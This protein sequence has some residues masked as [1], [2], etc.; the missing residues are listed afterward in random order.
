MSDS[1]IS[2]PPPSNFIHRLSRLIYINI[3]A[4]LELWLQTGYGLVNEFTDHLHTRLG[5]TRNYSASIN[6]H[7]SQITTVPSKFLQPAMSSSAIPWQRLLTMEILQLH[8]LSFCL[9][10]LP[11]RNQLTGRPSSLLYNFSAWTALPVSNSKSIV[12]CVF[13]S[14]ETCLPSSCSEAVILYSSVAN[15][16]LYRYSIKMFLGLVNL[17]KGQAYS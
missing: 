12:V 11:C 17:T 10:R 4:Y 14:A 5:I 6:F 1:I 8:A 3:I 16:L 7:N 15:K 2:N 13:V 9:H